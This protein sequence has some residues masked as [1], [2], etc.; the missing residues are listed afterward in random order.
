M[1][2]FSSSPEEEAKELA[3]D[4]HGRPNRDVYEV[5]TLGNVPKNLAMLGILIE[6][7]VWV[8]EAFSGE[9]VPLNFAPEHPS[10]GD[11]DNVLVGG[12]NKNGKG[13]I[14]FVGGDQGFDIEEL[15][16]TF[17]IPLSAVEGVEAINLGSVKAIAYFADKHHLEG[18]KA[19]KKGIP[20]EH[21]FAINEETEEQV[22]EPPELYY[23]PGESRFELIGGSYEIL[24]EG[25][26]G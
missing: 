15:A 3:R 19:Q 17:D 13:R 6:L 10:E 12:I 2:F 26:S 14:Y 18:P 21:Q 8:G 24:P 7:Q 11:E 5:V 9:Y 25:I 20:Y 23:M 4:F 1:G 16:E 22:G